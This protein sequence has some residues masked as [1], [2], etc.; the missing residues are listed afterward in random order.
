MARF[1]EGR[2]PGKVNPDTIFLSPPPRPCLRRSSPPTGG[3][4]R[5]M[6]PGKAGPGGS[7]DPTLPRHHPM[8]RTVVAITPGWGRGGSP[9]SVEENHTGP[10]IRPPRRSGRSRGDNPGRAQAGEGEPGYYFPLSPP[11]PCLR[12]SSPP[13]GGGSAGDIPGKACPGCR[14][15]LCSSPASPHAPDRGGNHPGEGPGREPP[16][17]RREPYWPSRDPP[18]RSGGNIGESPGGAQAGE[19]EPGY[20]FPL[21][22]PRPRLRRSSP[23]RGGGGAGDIPG[24]AGQGGS[25][26]PALPRHR[27]IHGTEEDITRGRGTPLP[28]KENHADPSTGPPRRSGRSRGDNPGRA[29]AGEGNLKRYPPWASSHA[30][31]Q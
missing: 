25:P 24:K 8:H 21:S 26:D 16:P 15:K 18:P 13:R 10:P 1:R 6:S 22:P 19:G 4:V 27:P 31:E 3:A 20:Y 2:K 30:P 11:R 28:V 7:P 5:V 23:P 12:R 17:R 14:P 29:Q 9:L